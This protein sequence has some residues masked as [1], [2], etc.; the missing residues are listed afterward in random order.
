MGAILFSGQGSQYVG[1]AEDLYKN[2]DIAKNLIEKAN[3][4]LGYSISEIMFKGPKEKLTETRFTQIAIFLHS[5]IIY[6]IV[7]ENLDIDAAAGHSVGELSALYAAG[8]IK[9][10]D[11]VKLVS[12]RGELMFQAGIDNPGTMF[13]VI[14]L[15]DKKVAQVSDQYNDP[16]NDNYIVP[17]NY[18]S[19]G[20]VVISGSRD[21]LKETAPKFKESGA[22]LVKELNVSGAF[23]SPLLENAKDEFTKLLDSTEFSEAKFPIYT[24][25]DAEGTTNSKELKNKLKQQLVSPV[26][27]SQSLVAMKDEGIS[28]FIE[29]GPGKVLQGLVKRTLSDV[30]ISGLDKYSDIEKIS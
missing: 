19:P 5:S 23:H 12:W 4:I 14:G 13:A 28:D 24:N 26:R 18:N 17:A 21:F 20:Q 6:D 1:M 22:R 29:I 2:S 15:D 30:S 10:D 27:W 25:I 7:K 3:E 8:V 16:E 11:A 9:F